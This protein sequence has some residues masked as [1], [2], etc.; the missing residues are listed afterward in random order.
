MV[1]LLLPHLLIS[2]IRNKQPIPASLL[3]DGRIRI[4]L[5][6]HVV[7]CLQ[8]CSEDW[9]QFCLIQSLMSKGIRLGSQHGK[10]QRKQWETL[11]HVKAAG[12]LQLF[13]VCGKILQVKEYNR[14][15][16]ASRR[17]WKVRFWEIKI[18]KNS[19]EYGGGKTLHPPILTQIHAGWSPRK[20]KT[21]KTL[22]FHSGLIP[23]LRMCPGN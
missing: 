5:I 18:F 11:G 21:D 4:K 3:W 17:N 1:L 6:C 14:T 12:A 2:R 7:T 15:S 23:M 22:G 13:N 20:K 9:F 19:H 8:F 10:G 16:K